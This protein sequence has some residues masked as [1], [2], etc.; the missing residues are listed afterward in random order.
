MFQGLSKQHLKQLHKKWKRIYGT[1]T[2]PS[3]SL[4]AKGRKEL[5]AIFHGSVHSKYTREILQALDYARNHYHF[6]TGASMLD[7]IIS[8]KRI[9]FNDYR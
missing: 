7:D 8:H 1:I 5:E 9:D 4:I 2:V 3:H 6:L